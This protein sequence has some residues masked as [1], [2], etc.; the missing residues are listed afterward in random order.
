MKAQ[1]CII[2][3]FLIS[4]LSADIIVQYDLNTTES[5]SNKPDFLSPNVSATSIKTQTNQSFPA[6]IVD[7]PE[8]NTEVDKSDSKTETETGNTGYNSQYL[9]WPR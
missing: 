6:T 8:K 4:F 3:L 1:A 2:N 9:K 5:N 7:N